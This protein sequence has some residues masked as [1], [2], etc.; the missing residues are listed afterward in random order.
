L[1]YDPD[2]IFSLSFFLF[3]FPLLGVF[4]AAHAV[5]GPCTT[6]MIPIGLLE[7]DEDSRTLVNKIGLTFPS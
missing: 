1:R 4:G 3:S 6:K 5:A 7:K 2:N